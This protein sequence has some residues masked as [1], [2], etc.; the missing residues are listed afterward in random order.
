MSAGAG[1]GQIKAAE[2]L[3]KSFA[4]DGRVAEVINTSHRSR[5]KKKPMPCV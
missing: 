3:E 4:A 1:N 5:G 2:V